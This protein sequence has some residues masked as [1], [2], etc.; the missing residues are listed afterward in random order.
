MSRAK[1]STRDMITPEEGWLLQRE[2]LLAWL[3]VAFA[4]VAVVVIQLNPSRTARF[5]TL[6]VFSL[7][8]FLFYSLFILELVRRRKVISKKIG[9]ITA[10]LDSVFIFLI[11]FSTGGT[12]TPF[13][14]YFSFPVLYRKPSLGN[15]RKRLR[16][17][18][19]GYSLWFD[20]L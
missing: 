6:S 11:V 7:G 8:S 3:R 12:R 20:T 1:P 5:P 4:I 14:F 15:Q 18:G 9:I 13:F 2:K 10:C 16:R 17:L 19:R